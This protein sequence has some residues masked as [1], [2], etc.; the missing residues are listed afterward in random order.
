MILNPVERY[1][2]KKSRKEGMEKGMEKG[3]RNGK[4]DDAKKMVA[5][6]FS[7]DVIVRITGLSEEDILNIK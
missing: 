4:L 2:D 5:E 3:M 1:I 7:I 6:G